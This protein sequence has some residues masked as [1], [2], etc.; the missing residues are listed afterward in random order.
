MI[1][2]IVKVKFEELL[3]AKGKTIYAIAKETGIAN[4]AL[5]KIKKGTVTSISFAVLEK[6]CESLDCTPNDLLWVEK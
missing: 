6:I 4:N 5:A 1:S 2:H 3:A